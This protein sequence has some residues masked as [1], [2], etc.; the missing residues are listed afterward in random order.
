M[1]CD[2]DQIDINDHSCWRVYC[3]SSQ[4]NFS[5]GLEAYRSSFVIEKLKVC[6]IGLEL[7]NKTHFKTFRLFIS[8]FEIPRDSDQC[9]KDYNLEEEE[10]K[11][12]H[13]AAYR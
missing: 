6:F 2:F 5:V 4:L 11:F 3:Y 13:L 9:R 10:G 12:Y 1:V 8:S 7:S